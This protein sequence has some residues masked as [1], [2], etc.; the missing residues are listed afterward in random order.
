[1]GTPFT[2][3]A[4]NGAP[5]TGGE[6]L[7]TECLVTRLACI[8]S[9]SAAKEGDGTERVSI[10]RLPAAG[11]FNVHHRQQVVDGLC[12]EGL[13]G[14]VASV[15]LPEY[16]VSLSDSA[17]PPL[18]LSLSD[19]MQDLGGRSTSA[20]THLS[21]FVIFDQ[22]SSTDLGASFVESHPQDAAS[23][24]SKDS[25]RHLDALGTISPNGWLWQGDGFYD[26]RAAELVAL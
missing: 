1:M 8:A 25:D 15:V 2:Q 19:P 23:S 14:E 3:Q 17:P 21:K 18:F 10:T 7:L 13:A 5:S 26:H 12:V 4:F 9:R 22:M 24:R 11:R 20:F 16:D 6:Y